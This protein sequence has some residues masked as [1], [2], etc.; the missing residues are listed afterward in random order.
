[1]E[2]RKV[3]IIVACSA[4]VS[5][6]MAAVI[7]PVPDILVLVAITVVLTSV[8]ASIALVTAKLLGRHKTSQ[9]Q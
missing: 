8:L 1:M 5:F 9:S 7:N 2:A 4:I 6:V 3:A